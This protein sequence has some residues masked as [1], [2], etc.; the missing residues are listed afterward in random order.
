MPRVPTFC[1]TTLCARRSDGHVPGALQPSDQLDDELERFI[2]ECDYPARGSLRPKP[3]S[4]AEDGVWQLK[5]PDLR[6]FGWF[7]RPGDF[8][9]SQIGFKANLR[10]PELY[11]PFIAQACRDRDSLQLDPPPFITGEL[12]HVL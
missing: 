7:W 4:P 2:S 10:R 3:L 9:V 1:E 12:A 5:T 11:R 8:I 6:V